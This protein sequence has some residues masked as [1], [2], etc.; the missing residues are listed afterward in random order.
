MGRPAKPVEQ[1][2][3]TGNPGQRKL[4]EAKVVVA[5][6]QFVPDPLCPLSGVGL[7]F[8]SRVWSHGKAWI[9]PTT[10]MDVVQLIAEQMDERAL[11]YQHILR[12]H[13]QGIVDWPVRS[14]LRKLDADIHRGLA[15][16]G[17]TP[18]MRTKLGLAEVRA[19]HAIETLINKRRQSG[20]SA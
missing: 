6:T 18:E 13:Q 2:R 17:F 16:I 4:P 12:Q 19:A 10:D 20:S 7:S 9:S 5:Q 8:W 3:R 14:Q 11:L 1:K 15:S